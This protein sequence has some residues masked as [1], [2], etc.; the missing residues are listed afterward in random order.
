MNCQLVYDQSGA[1]TGVRGPSVYN[2]FQSANKGKGWKPSKMRS[3]YI[4]WVT[5]EKPKYDTKII[6]TLS[7]PV[8]DVRPATGVYSAHAYM[9]QLQPVKTVIMPTDMMY[10]ED[11]VDM[12]KA[13][14]R[15]ALG[16]NTFAE[17]FMGADP[18][19]TRPKLVRHV[20]ATTKVDGKHFETEDNQRIKADSYKVFN[21]LYA[22]RYWMKNRQMKAKKYEIWMAKFNEAYNFNREKIQ[23]KL[24]RIIIANKLNPSD[25]TA[26][27]SFANLKQCTGEKCYWNGTECVKP[28]LKQFEEAFPAAFFL[29]MNPWQ[30]QE[31]LGRA[32]SAIESGRVD[33]SSF[34]TQMGNS[35]YFEDSNGMTQTVSVPE[36][37]AEAVQNVRLPVASAPRVPDV[38]GQPLP[39]TPAQNPSRRL[40][41]AART[42]LI[43]QKRV[44]FADSA[45]KVKSD[46]TFVDDELRPGL[47]FQGDEGKLRT[48]INSISK[49]IDD[50]SSSVNGKLKEVEDKMNQSAIRADNV[51]EIASTVKKTYD[52]SMTAIDTIQNEV[53]QTKLID[54]IDSVNRSIGDDNFV[55]NQIVTGF[56]GQSIQQLKQDNNDAF[57]KVYD[58]LQDV[59]QSEGV[60]L[61]NLI[62]P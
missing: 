45:K 61:P 50:V 22:G 59:A 56:N 51:D 58:T 6:N 38:S 32:K 3:E 35:F 52:E 41:F 20:P 36:Q 37:V 62:T 10:M 28:T 39:Q 9:N 7:G 16:G 13:I 44:T 31:F 12:S 1:R 49:K 17:G 43:Q 55:R 47:I 29:Q 18:V 33:L 60:Q 46:L 34:F 15:N 40:D 24:T 30:K 21:R 19:T 14:A 42:P 54:L 57:A 8:L 2:S 53:T 23:A 48:V 11:K 4:K 5:N 25:R 27:I 26:S